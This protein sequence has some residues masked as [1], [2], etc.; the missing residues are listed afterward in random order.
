VTLCASGV[1]EFWTS[2]R[3]QIGIREV[4]TVACFIDD[5]PHGRAM[6]YSS[7]HDIEKLCKTQLAAAA[8]SMMC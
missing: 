2:S 3:C 7:R 4:R 1:P 6:L 8:E 5:L